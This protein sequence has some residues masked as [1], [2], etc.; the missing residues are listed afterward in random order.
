MYIEYED[1]YFCVYDEND[2]YCWSFA[3]F[4]EALNYIWEWNNG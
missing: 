1:G 4:Q 3:T 2:N